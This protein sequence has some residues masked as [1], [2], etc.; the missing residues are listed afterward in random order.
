MK[1]EIKPP[2]I[3]A[4]IVVA[5]LAIGFVIN[6]FVA[7]SGDLDQGQVQSTPG[8]PPWQETDP[9]KK[10]PGGPPGGGGPGAGGAGAPS[11]N[12]QGQ[13]TAPP[14]MGAPTLGNK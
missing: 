3:I 12:P 2:A 14:G 10:G 1:S 11:V 5:V 7:H 8:K 9:S 13:P 6:K 4:I